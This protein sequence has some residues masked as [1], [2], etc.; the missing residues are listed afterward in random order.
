MA[1][2]EWIKL[3]KFSPFKPDQTVIFNSL[4]EPISFH[5]VI[6]FYDRVE[7]L[8][9]YLKSRSVYDDKGRKRPAFSGEIEIPKSRTSNINFTQDSYVD[10]SQ[11]FYMS[12]DEMQQYIQTNKDKDKPWILKKLDY[13]YVNKIFNQLIKQTKGDNPYIVLS[14]VSYNQI[15]KSIACYVKYASDRHLNNDYRNP[16]QARNKKGQKS[17]IQIM[18]IVKQNRKIHYIKTLEQIIRRAKEEYNE[19]QIYTPLANWITEL[20]KKYKW[21]SKEI[22][23]YCNNLV[24]EF[25]KNKSIKY[26]VP[27]TINWFTISKGMIINRKEDLLNTLEQRDFH[28]MLSWFKN[29]NLE[30]SLDSFE[31][32]KEQIQI[33]AKG[34][35]IKNWDYFNYFHLEQNLLAKIK[36]SLKKYKA[37][38]N[39]SLKLEKQVQIQNQETISDKFAYQNSNFP[40]EKLVPNQNPRNWKRKP[41]KVAKI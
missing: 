26:V 1:I 23:E 2:N 40:P 19:V 37:F 10:C 20:D 34:R 24:E 7:K 22:I 3:K 14:K 9:Y 12:K 36:T 30:L 16:P 28:F 5:P 39:P 25:D 15:T 18:N 41:K 27:A 21:N 11:I 32:F 35:K 29:N 8:Y 4:G 6:I 38:K 17:L 33:D 31:K 13:Q